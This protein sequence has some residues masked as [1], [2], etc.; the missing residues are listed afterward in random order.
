MIFPDSGERYLSTS[1]FTIKDEIG[2]QLF[3]SM[4][5]RKE[6]FEPLV[7]GKVSMHTCGPTAHARIHMGEC[8]RFVFSDMLVRY[9]R[10]RGFDVTHVM[11]ITDM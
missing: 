3:N 10:F 5:R 9:L 1:L 4:S 2:L 7:P 8:R 11:N 6:P